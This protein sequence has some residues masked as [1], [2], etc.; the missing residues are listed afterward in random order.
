M[1]NDKIDLRPAIQKL[2]TY[3][4]NMLLSIDIGDIIWDSD[5]DMFRC[6]SRYHL[7]D[8]K[9]V[10]LD[11]LASAMEH[12]QKLVL[13]YKGKTP[14][15][16]DFDTLDIKDILKLLPVKHE[17]CPVCEKEKFCLPIKNAIDDFPFKYHDTLEYWIENDEYICSECQNALLNGDI[18]TCPICGCIETG[19]EDGYCSDCY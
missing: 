14:N 6:D 9:A 12:W 4:L 18:G 11:L 17:K 10:P 15:D 2:A 8:I 13:F 3:D 5:S 19:G 7:D 1:I 16:P